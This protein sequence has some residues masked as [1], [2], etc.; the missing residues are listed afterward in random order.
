M[1][2]SS[3]KATLP[4][5]SKTL[6]EANA[7]PKGF[8]QGPFPSG[9]SYADPPA[10]GKLRGGNLGTADPG[11]VD[12][13]LKEGSKRITQISETTRYGVRKR[14]KEA[15]EQGMSPAEAGAYVR[16]WSGFD[17]Y[18][19]ERIA[20][21]EMMN[22]YNDA[23]LKSYGTVGVQMVVADD[24][25][26]DAECAARH[27]N[28]YTISDAL[29]IADHPNG[30][31]DWLPVAP[32]MAAR[33][34]QQTLQV[35]RGFDDA[36]L[37][38]APK[39]K[40]DIP[41]ANLKMMADVWKTGGANQQGIAQVYADTFGWDV[42]ELVTTLKDQIQLKQVQ[43][44]NALTKQQMDAMVNQQLA[45]SPYLMKQNINFWAQQLDVDPQDLVD[46]LGAHAKVQAQAKLDVLAK[47]D[48]TNKLT[49]DE[50]N[51][52][53]A[54]WVS[55]GFDPAQLAAKHGLDEATLL[56]KM[57]QANLEG[58]KDAGIVD[59]LGKQM[60]TGTA[61][62]VQQLAWQ[63]GV[64]DK[65]L[66]DAVIDSAQAHAKLAQTAKPPIPGGIP[67][68]EF[69]QLMQASQLG[70]TYADD[71]FKVMSDY[72]SVDP[73][74]LWQAMQA[75]AKVQGTTL[76]H[77][78]AKLA[79]SKPLPSGMAQKDMDDLLNDLMTSS[80]AD[81][82]NAGFADIGNYFGVDP[83]ELWD[84]VTAHAKLQGKVLPHG[85][86]SSV[87][88]GSAQQG[89]ASGSSTGATHLTEQ[90]LDDMLAKLK[91][92]PGYEHKALKDH[93]ASV[94]GVDPAALVS[95]LNN[96]KVA[97][98][99]KLPGPKKPK[100]PKAAKWDPA[101][102]QPKAYSS[103]TEM[104]HS[105]QK[106]SDPAVHSNPRA[107][108]LLTDYTNSYYSTVNPVLRGRSTYQAASVRSNVSEMLK[109]FQPLPEDMDLY[110]FTGVE[111]ALGLPK[112]ASHS[113][114][115]AKLQ[116]GSLIR[117]DAFVST[118]INRNHSWSGNLK[119]NIKAP[120]GSTR[121]VYAQSFSSHSS[122]W[123]VIL[124]PGTRFIVDAVNV[125]DNGYSKAYHVDVHIER[126][127]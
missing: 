93:W 112:G 6:A 119:L 3:A 87:S 41:D 35:Q 59:D 16:E 36:K 126:A 26:Q 46:A 86:P 124:E 74:E 8:K 72:Y 81:D 18:R 75:H 97:M 32:D 111:S 42:D 47:I 21:T 37:V 120:K 24:G 23:A 50:L 67:Q 49:A 125:I 52:L 10:P 39:V 14:I 48:K 127:K 12:Y 20:R 19:A 69:D 17:E 116:N 108:G 90:Q 55:G 98:G 109:P 76:P 57:K 104:G 29:A 62:D 61:L 45:A 5:V 83:D 30:T 117:D 114:I 95:D 77:V 13:A 110:R 73:D 118:S 99:G 100:V 9:R 123:E 94:N 65:E 115:M 53:A 43:N 11:A 1:T 85:K 38:D 60:S 54:D 105:L 122:E 106:W 84:A 92:T 22:A 7:A 31:L 25:D 113:Q 63:Y 71:A 91:T 121:G 79:Q 78:P 51:D 103:R 68:A 89:M 96:R 64:D 34:V 66:F 28:V 88:G 102:Y 27:G 44:L 80:V 82:F 101:K 15:I 40:Q 56:P 4:Y 107:K 70:K 33:E 2:S 58:I